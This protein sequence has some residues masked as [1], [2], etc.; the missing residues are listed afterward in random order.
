MP[1]LNL[2]MSPN[3]VRLWV[4]A[5]AV[6]PLAA[7]TPTFSR[8]VAPILYKH[9]TSCH[10]ANDIAPMALITYKDARPWAASIKDAILS[11]KCHRGRRIRRL[12]TGRTIPV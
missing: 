6:M 2:S 4:F 7:E 8:D 1:L 12:A 9:C 3:C 10:H 11:R 5:L